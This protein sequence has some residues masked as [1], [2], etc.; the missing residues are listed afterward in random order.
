VGCSEVP[1][2]HRETFAAALPAEPEFIVPRL[3]FC[4]ML[5]RVGFSGLR[6]A[7]RPHKLGG[8]GTFRMFFV[9]RSAGRRTGSP[10]A[11]SSVESPVGCHPCRGGSGRGAFGPVVSLRSTTG[12]MLRF[13][14]GIA[15]SPHRLIA[16]SPHRLIASSPHRLIASSAP[17]RLPISPISPI[18]RHLRCRP[19]FPLVSARLFYGLVFR[20]PFFELLLFLSPAFSR[21]PKNRNACGPPDGR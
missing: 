16:S 3:G 1:E 15:S 4:S 2:A 7:G 8:S 14:P 19:F 9:G 17:A 21:P 20:L 12:Y 11:G 10:R 5:G 6:R 13:P 18:S